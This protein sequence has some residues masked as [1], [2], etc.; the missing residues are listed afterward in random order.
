VSQLINTS[1][2]LTADQI[3]FTKAKGNTSRFIRSLIDR[4]IGNEQATERCQSLVK[5]YQHVLDR[6]MKKSPNI[7]KEIE[8]PID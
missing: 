5:A 3:T 6:P 2:T 7:P 4:E 8:A 1:V